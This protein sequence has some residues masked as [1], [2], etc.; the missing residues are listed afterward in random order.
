MNR[1]LEVGK[2]V[3]DIILA[4][5]LLVLFMPVMLVITAAIRLTEH[6]SA[7]FTQE[8]LTKDRRKFII[9]KFRSMQVGTEEDYTLTLENDSRITHIGKIIRRYRLDELPQLIN[10]LKGDM[11][12][13]GPR[14]ERPY[15]AEQIESELPEF[16]DRLRVKAGLTGYAQVHGKYRTPSKEKLAMDM[17]YIEHISLWMDL[18]LMFQTVRVIFDSNSAK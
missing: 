3:M 12:L 9:Y 13:V 5:L 16:A 4:L 18:K 2:R 17:Y 8:R 6:Q 7:F 14:P 11:S 1:R 15:I 10:V